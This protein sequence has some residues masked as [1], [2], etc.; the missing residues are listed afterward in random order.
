MKKL[1]A[2][3]MPLLVDDDAA[4]YASRNDGMNLYEVICGGQHQFGPEHANLQLMFGEPGGCCSCCRKLI[5]VSAAALILGCVAILRRNKA[6]PD[7]ALVTLWA[8]I[9]KS[10][11]MWTPLELA[12]QVGD[13][14][15]YKTCW[16]CATEAG[17]ET[18]RINSVFKFARA[19]EDAGHRKLVD[20]RPIHT[21]IVS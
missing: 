10:A 2:N 8:G 6:Y 13:T 4:S 20:R 1:L 17:T 5:S 15:G 18:T 3:T 21:Y 11:T 19:L 14:A 9:L 16:T 7:S 12:A